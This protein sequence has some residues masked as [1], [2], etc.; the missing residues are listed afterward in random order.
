MKDKEIQVVQQA[1]DGAN[2]LMLI[3]N[4][5][6]TDANFDVAKLEA[7]LAVKERWEREEARK[8]FVVALTAFK[9][10]P[11]DV[12][13]AKTVNFSTSHGTTNYKHATLA[14]ASAILGAAG[15]KQGLSH[16]WDVDQSK[17]G[18]IKVSCI[19]THV[20]GHSESISM[21]SAADQSGGKN[22][23][24]AI[25]SATSYLQR[26]TLFAAYGVAAK[27]QDDDGQAAGPHTD[28]VVD[29]PATPIAPPAPVLP[30][31]KLEDAVVF[32]VGSIAK[33][34]KEFKVTAFKT[35][36]QYWTLDEKVALAAKQAKT[37]GLDVKVLLSRKDGI[38]WIDALDVSAKV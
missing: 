20:L 2:A 23:I 13:K 21:E 1:G 19:L 6:A 8:A 9:A 11:P 24:Q 26:Y 30:D 14:D 38:L 29:K 15:A 27:D 22:S 35:L 25:G 5:A 31:G 17:E 10:D 16:R 12:F 18:K 28:A 4:R 36:E 7:L 37:D 33:R 34:D 3:I 32:K